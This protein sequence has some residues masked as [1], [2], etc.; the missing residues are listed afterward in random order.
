M[1]YFK[2]PD[3]IYLYGPIVDFRKQINGLCY[4]V[5]SEFENELF[6]NNWFIF[7]SKDKKEVKLLYW[8]KTGFAL[9]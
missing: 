6:D 4:I 8:R 1:L 2:K 3:K 5:E 9:W 7:I